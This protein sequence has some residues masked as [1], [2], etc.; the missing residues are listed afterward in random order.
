MWGTPLLVDAR[1]KFDLAALQLFDELQACS[2]RSTFANV[3]E[4]LLVPTGDECT[5]YRPAIHV[6]LD[7]HTR[8]VSGLGRCQESSGK[9]EAVVT[10]LINWAGE[11]G[12]A[13]P[14]YCPVRQVKC[15]RAFASR[16]LV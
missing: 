13:L 1:P 9:E 12:H 16:V 4:V 2:H 6:V 14:I 11:E 8:T 3:A 15:H 10:P 5:A 7:G